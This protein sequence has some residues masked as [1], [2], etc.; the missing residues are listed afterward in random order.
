MLLPDAVV[1]LE[2]GEERTRTSPPTMRE[3]D[4]EARGQHE[5]TKPITLRCFKSSLPEHDGKEDKVC[6]NEAGRLGEGVGRGL[7][8]S[9]DYT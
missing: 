8:E 3:L 6:Q 4:R 9:H 7:L 1:C 2:K 5:H